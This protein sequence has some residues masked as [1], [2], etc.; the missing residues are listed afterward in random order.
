MRAWISGL[1]L[2]LSACYLAH[3]LEEE[4]HDSGPVG[5]D[6]V[7]T[8][9]RPGVAG[10]IC[11]AGLRCDVGRGNLCTACDRVGMTPACHAEDRPTSC[12]GALDYN[13]S[14]DGDEDCRAPAR[15]VYLTVERFARCVRIGEELE[16]TSACDV[17]CRVVC[18]SPADCPTCASTCGPLRGAITTEWLGSSACQ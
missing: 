6:R 11:C 12:G 1:C 2:A 5:V 7:G 18:H 8:S 13:F 10:E 16:C 17:G 3:G 9:C 14:C 4:A 15:C